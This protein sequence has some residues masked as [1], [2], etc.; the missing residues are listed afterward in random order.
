MRRRG[1]SAAAM[2]F[3][4][5]ALV[6][7]CTGGAGDD[8]PL[9]MWTPLT[10]DDGAFMQQIVDEYNATGPEF[11]VRSL[12]SPSG[13][14]YTRMYS[15]ARAGSDIPDLTLV[16]SPRITEFAR[17]EALSP[18]DGL[19]T[20]QPGL[21][22]ENYLEA[23]WS[24]ATVDGQTWGIPLDLHGIIT[25]YNDD[26]LTEYD[27]EHFLD[28]GLVTVEELLTLEGRLDEGTY[29]VAGLFIPALVQSWQY[30]QGGSIGEPDGTVDMTNPRYVAAYEALVQLREAGL[31]APEDSDSMQVFN[32]GRALFMPDGTWG[33]SGHAA[34]DGLNFGLTNA[35]QL[36][37]ENPVNLLDSHLFVQMNDPSRSEARDR[38]VAAFLEYVRT[39]SLPWAEAG[40]IVASREIFDSPA[41]NDYPQA[42]FTSPEWEDLIVT[43]NFEYTAYVGGAFWSTT[44]DIVFGRVGIDEGLARMDA[45]I[46]V[47]IEMAEL[48]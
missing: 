35:V 13:D 24:A 19:T 8:E 10:G 33:Y 31:I 37:A 21:I 18:I 47:R 29:A 17:S 9:T 36:T 5:V 28:D 3:A 6:A 46:R 12:A 26:L 43:D 1:W 30:N 32:S 15:V 2:T 22:E 16:Q 23:A 11:E 41:Y 25:A 44:N 42:Q 7:A 34:I 4:L 48:S 27:V 45:E 20:A 39:N 40:Q 14:M 38:G